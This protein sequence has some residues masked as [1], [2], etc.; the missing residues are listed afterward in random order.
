[1]TPRNVVIEGDALEA[2]AALGPESVDC[3]VTSPP[4]Y[5][6]RDYGMAGQL[7]MEPTVGGWVESLRAVAREVWT[8]PG[9]ADTLGL[10]GDCSLVR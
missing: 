6:L 7:G 8:S 2:L 1:M 5:Q 9:L 3:V 4:Y 10:S